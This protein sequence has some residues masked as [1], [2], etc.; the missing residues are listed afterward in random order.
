MVI[1]GIV[2]PALVSCRAISN[3]L[4]NDEVVAAVG[5]YKLYRSDIDAV[6]PKGISAEDST[7]LAMQYINTWASDL[8]YVSIAEEQLSKTEKD[9]AKELEDYRKSLLKYRYEQLYVNERLDTAVSEDLVEEYY[10]AHQEKFILNRPLIKA[11]Y[12][13]ISS[14]SPNLVPIRRKMSSSEANDLIEA[15]SLAFSS[16]VKYTYWRN[17]WVDV[18]TLARE[19]GEDYASVMASMKDRWIHRKDTSDMTELAYVAEI[20]NAGDVAPLEFCRPQ[21]KDI[22]ISTRKQNLL[23]TLEQDLLKDARENGKFVIF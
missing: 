12:L 16:A 15:D 18:T 13:R 21:I 6:V 10:N 8:V 17:E 23:V 11:R 1:S 22:I 20:V 5:L 2:L 3:F 9:V 19:F 4:R 7:R 14:D